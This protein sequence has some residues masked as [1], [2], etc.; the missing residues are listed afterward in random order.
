LVTS[1]ADDLLRVRQSERNEE[2]PRLVHVV[3]V[4]IDHHNLGFFFWVNA[5]QAV[6]AEGAPSATA[7]DHDSLGHH[8]IV[9]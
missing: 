3:V 9:G 2:Q 8:P 6:C 1:G 7:K 4:L 5:P